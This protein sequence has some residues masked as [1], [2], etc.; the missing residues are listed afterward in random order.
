M[1]ELVRIC[2]IC[3]MQNP[4]DE[5]FCTCGAFLADVDF[6]HI[7][8]SAAAVA[9]TAAPAAKQLCPHED[10]AQPN[11]AGA[12]LCVYCNRPLAA[13]VVEVDELQSALPPTL[14][15]Q[16][17]V[18]E[19]L[20]TEGGQ[21]DL[22]LVET[23]QQ[24][25]RVV[26]LYRRGIQPD[27][28]VLER[29]PHV[30]SPHLVTI[31]QHGVAEHIAFEVMTYCA[32]GS[33][34]T[35]INNWPLSN[36][37]LRCLIEQLGTTLMALHAQHILHR[38]LKPE[39]IL[40][41]QSH[42]LDIALI[43]FGASSLQMAT[44]YFT[45][46]ARTAH[47][48][49]PEVLTGVLDEKSDWWAVGMMLLE[50]ITGRHPY[51]G[52]SEQV[53]LH[54]LAT[55]S[56]EV[57]GV[58]DERLRMLCRGLLLRNPSKRW[59]GQAL[60][61]WLANDPTL[62]MPDDAG[63]GTAIR[64]YT[65]RKVQCLSRTDLALAL[66]QHWNDGLKD[67]RRGIITQWV[68]QDLRDFDLARTLHD[69][70]ARH[71]LTDDGRLLRVIVSALPGIPPVWQG[72]VITQDTLARAATQAKQG[73]HEAQMW[74]F[75]IY[76]EGVLKFLGESGNTDMLRLSQAWKTSVADYRAIWA[77]S[78][79]LEED[80]RRHPTT[81]HAQEV[82]DVDYLLYL[83][84]IRMNV[85]SLE[86]LLPDVVLSLY[87]PA[88]VRTAQEAIL[89]A[90]AT[91]VEHC[92]WFT[93]LVAESSDKPDVFWFVAQAL[94]PFAIED[95]GKENQRRKQ[96]VHNAQEDVLHIVL[97]LQDICDTLLNNMQIDELTED[98]IAK[99]RA[100]FKTW[101]EF[102]IW[103]KRL[104]HDN[105]ALNKILLQLNTLNNHAVSIQNFL[106]H[107]QHLLAINA[108]WLKPSRVIFATLFIM[109]GFVWSI[110][111][112]FIAWS[113]LA[114]FAYTRHQKAKHSE[115][116]GFNRLRRMYMMLQQFRQQNLVEKV[117]A[118]DH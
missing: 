61:R 70:L 30:N 24:E 87:L 63:D 21:A 12:L 11:P 77:R 22:V 82:V 64:P 114:I 46:G 14:R 60:L 10:C 92:A 33:V 104:K 99:L 48:A 27:W 107:H 43:D 8:P 66:A 35:L 85:P 34:R 105:Q 52:L 103:M 86:I 80:N 115:D 91:T 38:D 3:G 13:P 81:H 84:P 6:T 78:K 32:A 113:L 83:A 101:M 59:G 39:N 100:A 108:I 4:P 49:A 51:A 74:L 69:T 88:F 9:S 41:R 67:L 118:P 7:A 75:S 71:E 102:V 15:A 29:L 79:V 106:D 57:Q 23:P 18:L 62:T 50:A 2:P 19:R 1:T 31:F 90:C 68:E 98:E 112:P 55:Q 116:E 47:Y 40:L 117:T 44:Q 96:I 16:F 109:G 95:A 37:N 42:P 93:R 36:D 58:M 111:F 65:L 17:R 25:Q 97:K 94:L 56:V 53:A 28:Q 45:K 110:Y 5:S 76:K 73:Q 20:P 54:Q 26:K 72:K 89:L